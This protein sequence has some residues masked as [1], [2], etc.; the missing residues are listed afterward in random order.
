MK[1]SAFKS[2]LPF[3]LC[4]VL[5]A[6]TALF[7]G[8]CGNTPATEDSNVTPDGSA[9]FSTVGEGA[10][11]FSF[12]VEGPEGE[13]FAYEVHTDETTV[14]AAL[15]ENGLIDGEEGESGIYVKTVNG[16]TLDYD[17]DK[18]YWAFY[19]DGDYS[20]SSVDLTDIVEGSTYTFKA[21]KW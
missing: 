2:W 14:G 11:I 12:T 13:S 1:K 19:I 4:T 3:I 5:I 21:E 16:I 18:M 9:S 7:T 17:N 15:V 6:A 20:A 10:T 8:G